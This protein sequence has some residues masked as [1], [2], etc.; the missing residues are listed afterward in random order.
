ML[1]RAL[2]AVSEG[3]SLIYIIGRNDDQIRGHLIPEFAKLAATIGMPLVMSA[4]NRYL[5]TVGETRLVRFLDH[6]E[7]SRRLIAIKPAQK[8]TDHYVLEV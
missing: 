2:L 6:S 8:F 5:F 4:E 3:S 7:E 1:L